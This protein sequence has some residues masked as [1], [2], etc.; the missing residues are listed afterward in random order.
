MLES[1]L[2]GRKEKKSRV[3]SEYCKGGGSEKG[4][5]WEYWEE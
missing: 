5:K 4:K 2:N 3:S 1:K